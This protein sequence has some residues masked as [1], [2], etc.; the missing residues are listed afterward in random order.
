MDIVKLVLKNKTFTLVLSAVLLIGGLLAFTNMSRLE[1]PDFTIKEAL[2]ITPYFGA[3]PSEVAEEV[4]DE[5]ENAV[6]QMGQLDRV[7]SQSERGFSTVTVTIKETYGKETIPQIWD[8]LRRKVNDAQMNLPPGAGPPIVIDDYGDVYGIFLA[9]Y[10]PEY[11]YAELK[12]TVDQLRQELLLVEGVSK[13]TTFGER[14]EAIYVELNRDRMAQLGIPQYVVINELQQKSLVSVSGSVRVGQEFIA[15]DPTGDISSVEEF[16]SIL[17]SGGT[18]QLF[19]RDIA[20]VRRDYVDPQAN[21]IRYDGQEAIAMGVSTVQGGNVVDMGKALEERL[22]E[23]TDQIPLGMEVGVISYQSTAVQKA[24][25]GFTES[26]ILAVVIVIVVLLLF[27][28]LR[29]GLL[30]GFVLVLTIAGSFIFLDPMGVALE[31][32]SLGALIIALGMLVDNAIVIVDGMLIQMRKGVARE[33][34]ASDVVKQTALPLL[35]ATLIAILAFAAIGTSQNDT[36]EF[37]RSL[38]NVVMVSLLLSWVTAITITPLLGVMYLKVPKNADMDADPYGG[39]FYTLYKGFLRRCIRYRALTLTAVLVAFVSALMAFGLISQSFFPDSTR[40]QFMVDFWMPQGTHIEGVVERAEAIEDYLLDQEGVSNVTSILGEGALRF[41]LTYGPELSNSSYAQFLV[42]VDD[43]SQ[44]DALIPDIE[45]YLA[46]RFPEANA[47]AFRFQIG[48]GGKGKIRARFMGPD[49]DVLRDLGSQAESIMY[50]A[51]NIKGIRTDW[52][53][54][55]KLLQPQ[56]AE[57]Q[58]S[59]NGI[60]RADIAQAMLQGFEGSQVGVYR[61]QDLLLPIILRA[62]EEERTQ[63]ESMN[64]IL[65]WSPA[66]QQMIPIRQVVSGFETTFEDAIIHKRNRKETLTVFGDPVTGPAMEVFKQVRPEI[67][68]IPLPEGYSL[69]WG[70]DYEDSAK[71]EAALARGIPLFVLLMI[72]ITIGL[73]NSFRKTT[74]VWLCVPLA[75]IGVSTGLLVTGQPFGFMALLGFLSLMGMLIKNAIVLI[76]EINVQSAMDKSLLDAIIDAGTNRLRPV[77]LAASTTA[78]GMIPLFYDAFFVAMAVTIVF[79]LL[80]ATLLTV[81]VVPVFYALF[82]RVEVPAEAKEEVPS[83]AD[84]DMVPA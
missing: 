47:Y 76:D 6:Q 57:D 51:G 64:D 37:L 32:V 35:G 62:P 10:G 31:R 78:L 33:K 81:V 82:Y 24:I 12:A 36:G 5:I 26:L 74:I 14:T 9:L 43:L 84:I 2:V 54:R 58:A 66:A 25:D 8:E 4:T 39:R 13:I 27:M 80:F 59:L 21:M 29:S 20:T 63:V 34:A 17:I 69:E 46:D 79:G 15:I 55:V 50:Q 38:F 52:R 3:S 23:L 65:L 72:L 53:Q 67:E 77:G 60:Q 48:P 28:G 42:D 73:F 40:P 11:S 61:E 45:H 49:P 56:I 71:A 18:R 22:A 44:I 75:I 19:L 1:D 70:G 41:V 30:I 83:S 7:V 68:A 16:E